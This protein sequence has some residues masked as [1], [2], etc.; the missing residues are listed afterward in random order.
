[1][2]YF[3]IWNPDD[4]IGEAYW[5]SAASAEDARQAI[6]VTPALSVPDAA[7][8]SKFKCVPDD[9]KQPGPGLISRALYGPVAIGAK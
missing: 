4:P 8:A 6:A 5:V 3:K 2:T 7:D 1:V 9:R